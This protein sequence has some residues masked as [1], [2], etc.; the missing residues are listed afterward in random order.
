MALTPETARRAELLARYTQPVAFTVEVRRRS[1]GE[2][3]ARAVFYA[4]R[5]VFTEA[6]VSACVAG[7]RSARLA[8]LLGLLLAEAGHTDADRSTLP[9]SI[10]DVPAMSPQERRHRLIPARAP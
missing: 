7:L 1:T 10:A 4:L 9:R 8:C 5:K 6:I 3:V 2:T